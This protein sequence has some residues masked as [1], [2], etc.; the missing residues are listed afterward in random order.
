VQACIVDDGSTDD[1]AECAQEQ[2]ERI[3]GLC[4]Q[5][6]RADHQGVSA[7]R[8]TALRQAS[9]DWIL[10]LDAD[11][12]LLADPLNLLDVAEQEQRTA[13]C[14][15][16]N[17]ERNGRQVARWRPARIG[18][19]RHLAVLTAGN[20]LPIC[21]LLFRRQHLSDMFDES[22][23]HGED[24]LLWMMNPSVFD[25]VMAR[26]DVTIATVHLRP[27]SATTDYR[28]WG[29]DRQRIA[30]RML[31]GPLPLTR[32]QRNNL[33]IQRAI[34]QMQSRTGSGWNALSAVP[35]NLK[36]W[37]KLGVYL[38]A[39]LSGRQATRYR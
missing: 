9:G 6:H 27:G 14:C 33:R 3:P 37:C 20:P 26:R 25:N 8:N 17:Y 10:M 31:S 24:W 16:V 12:E 11:D 15:S 1:S 19:H 39:W 28:A 35:C 34:G 30:D 36:L 38:S 4:L 22:I 23:A 5:L 2:V 7:A 13:V 21:S 18:P 32:V 29:E